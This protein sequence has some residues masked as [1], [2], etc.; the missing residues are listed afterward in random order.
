MQSIQSV[1]KSVSHAAHKMPRSPQKVNFAH[2]ETG[3]NCQEYLRLDDEKVPGLS[4]TKLP[5][6]FVSSLLVSNRHLI[7]FNGGVCC[8]CC[9]YCRIVG[10]GYRAGNFTRHIYGLGIFVVPPVPIP[11]PLSPSIYHN[12]KPT[13]LL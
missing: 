1:S 8:G 5:K 4:L 10:Y 2:F 11:L 12:S 6:I 3:N 9:Y 7:P 13:S